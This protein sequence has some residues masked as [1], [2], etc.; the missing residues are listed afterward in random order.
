MIATR[1]QPNQPWHTADNW[2]AA[3]HCGTYIHSG[4]LIVQIH[5]VPQLTAATW[6][7]LCY[8][9]S[10][11]TIRALVSCLLTRANHVARSILSRHIRPS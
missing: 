9:V 3:T 7:P 1:T 8:R 2:Q 11:T 6:C 10:G 4:Q 5:D